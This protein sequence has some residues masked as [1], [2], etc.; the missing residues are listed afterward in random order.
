MG[1]R[2]CTNR[3]PLTGLRELGFGKEPIHEFSQKG[4]FEKNTK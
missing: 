2:S 1:I 4:V 3:I